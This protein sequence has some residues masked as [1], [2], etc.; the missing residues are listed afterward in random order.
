MFSKLSRMV[1]PR[2]WLPQLVKKKASL[3]YIIGLMVDVES[4]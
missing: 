2:K 4:P 1:P 3:G